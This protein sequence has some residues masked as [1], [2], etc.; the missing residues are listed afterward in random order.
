V[1]LPAGYKKEPE[2]SYPVLYVIDGGVEQDLLH[3][4]GAL[5]L[6]SVWGR[7]ADAIV[8]GIETKNRRRELA[9]PTKDPEL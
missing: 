7:S 1:I 9:G 2:K 8:V 3:V 5:H 4:T 6:G